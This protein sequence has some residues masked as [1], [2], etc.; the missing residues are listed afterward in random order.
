MSTRFVHAAEVQS[1]VHGLVRRRSRSGRDSQ[2]TPRI[3]R[4]LRRVLDGAFCWCISC[5]LSPVQVRV[6]PIADR[7]EAYAKSLRDRLFDLDVRA[8]VDTST[9]RMQ[10]KIRQA[11]LLKVPY[12]LIVGNREA[13]SNSASVRLRTGADLGAVQV[14]RFVELVSGKI[15]DKALE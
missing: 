1:H 13:E 3:T 10:W 14:D 2:G 6:I 5:W 11:Q 15:R 9:Q 12:M 7:H 8:D 4:A